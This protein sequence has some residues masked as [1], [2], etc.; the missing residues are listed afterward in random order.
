MAENFFFWLYY[1]GTIILDCQM[2]VLTTF[3]TKFKVNL[4]DAFHPSK[5]RLN[6]SDNM[7]GVTMLFNY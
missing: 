6:I 5:K 1:Y 7:S 4:Y 3:N 2:T